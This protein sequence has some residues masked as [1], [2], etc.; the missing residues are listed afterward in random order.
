MLERGPGAAGLP[1]L[2]LGHLPV[3]IVTGGHRDYRDLSLCREPPTV[4]VVH[5]DD[6]ATRPL[7]REQGG[8]GREVVLEVGVKV[9][10]VLRQVGEAGDVVDDP[11]DAAQHQ[12]VAG[13]LHYARRGASLAHHREQRVQLRRL[14]CGTHA[15]K[16]L[17]AYPRLDGSDQTGAMARGP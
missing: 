3:G 1:R 14:R 11:V 8:L 2:L 12:R 10:M 15:G 13:H 5:H 17:I 9:Q 7:R 16:L 6:P 4:V